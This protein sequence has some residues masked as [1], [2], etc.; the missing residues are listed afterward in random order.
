MAGRGAGRGGWR[1]GRCVPEHQL[2]KRSPR[3]TRLPR[4]PGWCR[5]RPVASDAA[6]W[7]PEGLCPDTG[8]PLGG[9]TVCCAAAWR[10]FR[11]SRGILERRGPW[12][13][14]QGHGASSEG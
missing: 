5:T 7:V 3:A 12:T 9:A 14:R 1:P 13:S 2:A 4:D 10:I 11:T 8:R 6:T